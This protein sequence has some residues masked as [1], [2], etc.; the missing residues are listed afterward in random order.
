LL[1][2]G[3]VFII[4]GLYTILE[5]I[6]DIS[7]LL[8]EKLIVRKMDFNIDEYFKLKLYVGAFSIIVG[9]LSIINYLMY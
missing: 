2:I 6:I 4:L 7:T 8:K 3:I 1:Y 5:N 9:I